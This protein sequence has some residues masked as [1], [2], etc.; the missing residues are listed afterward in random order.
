MKFTTLVL[1]LL[2]LTFGT[3][4][5]SAATAAPEA[6]S[7]IDDLMTEYAAVGALAAV[8]GG[9]PK[10]S[11]AAVL[12]DAVYTDGAAAARKL[13]LKLKAEASDRYDLGE[14]QLNRL[15]Y[16][17][18]RGGDAAAGLVMLELNAEA[19]PDSA[20]AHDSLAEARE[21]LGNT[22]LAIASYRRVLEIDPDFAHAADRLA[23][24]AE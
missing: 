7:V 24:L 8:Y 12:R 9:Q 6:A 16:E 23:A 19:F 3:A 17:L 20:N 11:V 22:E 14:D 13:Y 5:A 1:I 18:L 21:R 10:V 15:G 4:G 2:L